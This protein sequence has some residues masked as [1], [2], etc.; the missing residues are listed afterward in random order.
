VPSGGVGLQLDREVALCRP[1]GGVHGVCTQVNVPA[2]LHGEGRKGN[3]P[4]VVHGWA[5]RQ[6]DGW[7]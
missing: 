1:G 4:S 2:R 3:A 7:T 6:V 5:S